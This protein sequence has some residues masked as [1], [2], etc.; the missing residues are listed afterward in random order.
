LTEDIN[1]ALTV[2]GV[3]MITV[4]IIL[5]LVV[6]SGHLLIKIVNRFS[7]P[8]AIKSPLMGSNNAHAS[9]PVSK[10]HSNAKIAALVSAVDILTEGR[11][12]IERIEKID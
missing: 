3:G 6:L 11:G 4:F 8:S 2:L 10:S 7:P 1:N 9:I 5:G 12:R